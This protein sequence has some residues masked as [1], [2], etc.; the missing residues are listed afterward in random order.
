MVLALIVAVGRSG[1]AIRSA[2]P[3]RVTCAAKCETRIIC[4]SHNVKPTHQVSCLSLCVQLFVQLLFDDDVYM[5]INYEV[6]SIVRCLSQTVAH[7]LSISF[8]F[9]I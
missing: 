9:I 1:S 5:N 2:V 4:M 3:A 7:F 6:L 8:R